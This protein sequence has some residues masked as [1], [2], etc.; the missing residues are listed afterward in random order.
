VNAENLTIWVKWA[1]NLAWFVAAFRSLCTQARPRNGSA[2]PRNILLPGNKGIVPRNILPIPRNTTSIPGKHLL[3]ALFLG[4]TGGGRQRSLRCW[5]TSPPNPQVDSSN[6][7][8]P[9][10]FFVQ[11]TF[12]CHSLPLYALPYPTLM[13]FTRLQRP[14]TILERRHYSYTLCPAPHCLLLA[15]NLFSFI[16]KQA[17]WWYLAPPVFWVA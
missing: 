5:S 12:Y 11:P 8:I 9:Q 13:S 6:Q 7:H 17:V 2:F 1:P 14:Q 15:C 10:P 3:R 16:W 4:T